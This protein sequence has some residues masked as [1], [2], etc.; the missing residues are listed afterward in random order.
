[1]KILVISSNY[2][3]S[4][5]PQLGTFVYRLIQEFVKMNNE[6]FVISPQKKRTG[7]Y[8]S[9]HYGKEKAIVFRPTYWSFSN[10]KVLNWNTYSLTNLF[11]S[12]AIKKTILRH[13][14]V[15]DIIY[16]HF[17][18]SA[19]TYLKSSPKSKIPIF[20]AVG[21]YKNIDI[22]RSY[23][24]ESKYEEYL[25]K[26]TGFIAVSMQVKKKLLDIGVPKEKILIAQNGVDLDIFKPQNKI[27]L[28]Q[29]Y[30]IPLNQKIVIFIGRFLEQKG[31]LRALE[32][33]EKQNDNVG[34]ICI[35]K[36][37]QKIEGDRVL[38]QG[39]LPHKQV[40]EYLALSDIFILPTLHEGS[41]NVIVEAIASGLPIISSNIPEIREQCNS[42][43][44]IL[45]DPLNID[46]IYTAV[47]TLTTNNELRISMSK[48]ALKKSSDFNL[49][50]RTEKILKFI[51][52]N[53]ES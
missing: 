5:S 11:T 12:R 24:Q 46:Q 27:E 4:I 26:I 47:K 43:F 45:V 17:I 30:K 13:E 28:R 36:G 49:S 31:P 37:P 1:M 29:K 53:L 22:V 51:N 20:V 48:N 3:N 7:K 10:K 14:I 40:A 6:V 32:A 8:L 41:S 38:F 33:V 42:S 21:E 18:N 35:G 52:D 15:P 16:C 39:V 19:L 9:K 50:V 44:S 25:D 34:I 23:Y 2:P